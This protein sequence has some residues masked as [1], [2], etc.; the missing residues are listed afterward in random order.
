MSSM[1]QSHS[2]LLYSAQSEKGPLWPYMDMELCQLGRGVRD[3]LHLET[4]RTV[5]L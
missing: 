3:Q 2:L 1:P 5:S 4:L